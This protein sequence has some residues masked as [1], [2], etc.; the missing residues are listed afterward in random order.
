MAHAQRK[1]FELSRREALRWV[2]APLLA[3]LPRS[4][5]SGVA[6]ISPG[7]ENDPFQLGG[8]AGYPVADGVVLWTRL[9]PFPF[10]PEGV[11]P[12][13]LHVHWRVAS[14]ERMQRTVASGVAIA[15][16]EL[17]HSVHVEV[18]QLQPRTDYFYQFTC[19]GYESAVGHT[20]TTPLPGATPGA[21]FALASCQSYTDGYFTAYRDM[22]AHDLDFILH[23]G[24]YVYESAYNDAI[25]RIPVTEARDL[26][27]YR[28][29]HAQ[30]K[31]DPDL[32]RA[33]AHC[34]WFVTWD[35]HEVANDWG[36]DYGPA[37]PGGDWMARKAAASQAY[38]EH[39]P[40]RLSARPAYGELRLYGRALFGDLLE[41]NLFDVRQYRDLPACLDDKRQARRWVSPSTCPGIVDKRR[42][43]L[44]AEQEK[45]L[46][47]GLGLQRCRWTVLAQHGVFAPLDMLEE[48][49]L[50]LSQDGWDGYFAT[51]QRI[52]DV[53][54]ERAIPNAISLGGDI[55]SFY[56]GHVTAEPLN[57]ASSPVLTEIV[58]TS[59]T[60]SGGGEERYQSGQRLLRQQPFASYWDNRWHG[61]VLNEVSQ[62]GW[63][64]D[65]RKV[66]SVR[67]PNSSISLL[68]R[69]EVMAG[70]VGV[71]VK[72]R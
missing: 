72:K 44:G 50:Q 27:G 58:T 2:A 4:R 45:G 41:I 63:Q 28:A 57:A 66:D 65:L 64:A 51:R 14:D 34:P 70:R 11:D 16:P 5:G 7:F 53:L 36:G 71:H 21:R 47:R 24:D 8:A 54:R 35:D 67:I 1:E 17:A 39:M 25:R 6:A 15:R 68:D 56:A 48:D 23:V 55:H 31:L 13:P 69:L 52:L 10:E 26:H 12:V 62:Q 29:L 43:L 46:L 40:L 49:G 22:A 60:A 20:R 9:A 30:Y 19:G 61:Y 18:F 59:V 42:T 3:A 38:Y 37:S 33:H 32:R